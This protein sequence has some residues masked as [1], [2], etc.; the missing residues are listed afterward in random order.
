M[1]PKLKVDRLEC[2]NYRARR[3]LYVRYIY[4]EFLNPQ[5]CP[6]AS[7]QGSAGSKDP[8]RAPGLVAR[9]CCIRCAR[10]LLLPLA[11]AQRERRD[12]VPG[13]RSRRPRQVQLLRAAA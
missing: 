10:E 9:V 8:K 1:A 2:G 6:H 3:Q 11:A 5:K 12:D 4:T 13:I 7:V